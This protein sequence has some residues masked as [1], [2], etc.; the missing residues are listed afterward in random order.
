MNTRVDSFS[1]GT[2]RLTNGASVRMS[3]SGSTAFGNQ[4]GY[5]TGVLVD[6]DG[7]TFRS[8]SH[9]IFGIETTLRSRNALINFVGANPSSV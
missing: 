9:I 1:T 5:G 3:S 8:D 2:L 7:S 6:I 4:N